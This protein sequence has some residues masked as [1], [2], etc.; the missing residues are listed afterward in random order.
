M[1]TITWRRAGALTGILA[2]VLA[3]AGDAIATS[4]GTTDVHSS[5]A[6]ILAALSGG[7]G[8]AWHLGIGMALLG[9]AG[10]MVFAAYLASLLRDEGWLANATLGSGVLF[11]AIKLGSVAPV[12]EAYWRA[13]RIDA[14]TARTLM[15]LGD[16]AFQ[17]GLLPF[18]L[19]V[20]FAGA[21]SLRAGLLPRGLA[22]AGIVIGV[23]GVLVMPTGVDGPGGAAWML[24]LLWLAATSVVL[25]QRERAPRGRPLA[26]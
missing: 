22:I 5:D 15:D 8:A 16:F 19:L 12:W 21:G 7:H 23:L 10:L 24:G 26:V 25:A 6:Q 4:A 13:P 1:S 18:A 3:F 17:V 14:G 11:V 2:I 9:F 20:G